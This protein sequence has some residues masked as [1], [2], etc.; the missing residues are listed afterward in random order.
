MQKQNLTWG[1][2]SGNTGSFV[3]L[4]AVSVGCGK[5]ILTWD[6][7]GAWGVVGLML[8][9]NQW[10]YELNMKDTKDYTLFSQE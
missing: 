5:M 2:M 3:P 6:T 8:P 1:V 9:W 4:L 10:I 7:A